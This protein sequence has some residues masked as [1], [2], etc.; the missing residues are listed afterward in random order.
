[1]ENLLAADPR[2][3]LLLA[4]LH[5]QLRFTN[6]E[7][8]HFFFNTSKLDNL[9]YFS[10]LVQNDPEVGLASQKLA[11]SKKWQGHFSGAEDRLYAWPPSRSQSRA[12]WDQKRSVGIY[13][14]PELKRTPAS[15]REYRTLS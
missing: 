13:G 15:D 8:I 10:Q 12:V 2:N 7:L 5:R 1:M 11:S 6:I 14:V 3:F 4:H 9:E